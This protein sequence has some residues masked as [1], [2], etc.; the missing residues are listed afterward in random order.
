MP[1]MPAGGRERRHT[2]KQWAIPQSLSNQLPLQGLPEPLASLWGSL[3]IREVGEEEAAAWKFSLG[4]DQK[5]KEEERG[6][7]RGGKEKGKS[8]L[9]PRLMGSTI[10]PQVLLVLAP[11]P[12]EQQPSSLQ[13]CLWCN[14]MQPIPRP[15]GLVYNRVLSFRVR[16]RNQSFH[17]YQGF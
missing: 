14:L 11:T 2:R 13:A 17:G 10:P 7:R 4:K 15:Q 12:P 1:K 5:E 16:P 3:C 8:R 9:G 6:G